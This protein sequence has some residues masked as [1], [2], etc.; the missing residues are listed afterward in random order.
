M[1]GQNPS[2]LV[3]VQRVGIVLGLVLLFPLMLDAQASSRWHTLTRKYRGSIFVLVTS[4]NLNQGVSNSFFISEKGQLVTVLPESARQK[5]LLARRGDGSFLQARLVKS[6]SSLPLAVLQVAVPRSTAV[7]FGD[8]N[9][10][11]VGDTVGILGYTTAGHLS[12]LTST[13]SQIQRLA[14]GVKVIRIS[15]S[16]TA[17][18]PGA[19]VFDQR[20]QVIGVVARMGGASP[21]VLP[22]GYLQASSAGKSPAL[23]SPSHNPVPPSEPAHPLWTKF[24][25]IVRAA[26]QIPDLAVRSKALAAVGRVLKQVGLDPKAQVLFEEAITTLEKLSDIEERSYALNQVALQLMEARQWERALQLANQIP[27]PLQKATLMYELSRR[28]AKANQLVSALSIARRIED[29]FYRCRALVSVA[30][31]QPPQTPPA[32]SSAPTTPSAGAETEPS[33]STN[34]AMA[35]LQEAQQLANQLPPGRQ[36]IAASAAVAVGMLLVGQTEAGEALLKQA[37]QQAQQVGGMDAEASLHDIAL[38]LTEHQQAEKAQ[39]LLEQLPAGRRDEILL[40]LIEAQIR[41]GQ[42]EQVEPLTNRMRDGRKQARA[43]LLYVEHLVR[44]QQQA[45]ARTIASS[46]PL[47]L[48]RIQAETQ[49]FVVEV[50]NQPQNTE[51]PTSQPLVEMAQRLGDPR[52]RPE[53]LALVAAACLHANK[54]EEGEKLFQEALHAAQGVGEPWT[55]ALV[56]KILLMQAEA[57]QNGTPPPAPASPSVQ[58]STGT[59]K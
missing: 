40:H 50:R 18:L 55:S 46:I 56:A 16:P 20:N 24:E 42:T 12:V 27:D 26:R 9:R 34:P 32:D 51:A 48:E 25:P 13:V 57:L 4:E 29:P 2:R 54:I 8:S 38:I 30:I 10:V 23:T 33:A 37:I 52:Q 3:T 47:S 28:A 41:K 45:T 11:K 5:A 39:P 6:Y 14:S 53:A 35:L 43:K 15:P 22:I 44:Q 1:W 49:L 19:P 17:F 21:E 31:A 36:Q 59:A 7:R 58:T